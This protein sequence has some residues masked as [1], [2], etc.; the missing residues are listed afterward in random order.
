MLPVMLA[1]P[2][3]HAVLFNDAVEEV[4]LY[5]SI[6]S[7]NDIL[8]KPLNKNWYSILIPSILKYYDLP[9][10]VKLYGNKKLEYK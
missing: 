10:L 2:A 5:N 4:V 9:D 8:D 3:L 6:R 1:V 7:F